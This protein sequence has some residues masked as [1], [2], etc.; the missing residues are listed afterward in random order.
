MN[1]TSTIRQ[2]I[3]NK[4]LNHIKKHK[5]IKSQYD[6]RNTILIQMCFT[7]SKRL[8]ISSAADH[9]NDLHLYIFRCVFHYP[10]LS[11]LCIHIENGHKNRQKYK[12]LRRLHWPLFT[13]FCMH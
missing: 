3:T 7:K 11:Q 12:D 9:R 6:K 10:I 8:P 2:V 13:I 5:D 4:I 1:L